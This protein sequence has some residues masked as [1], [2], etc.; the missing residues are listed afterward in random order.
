VR[1]VCEL[2][3]L[4][5]FWR[6]LVFSLCLFGLSKQWGDM[7]QLLPPFLERYFGEAVPYYAIASINMWVCMI[8]PSL[9]AALTSHL[10]PFVVM[11]P[12]IWIM[13]G[14]PLWLALQPSVETSIAWVALLS[15]G[16]AMW[17][18][19]Q[20]AWIAN[21]APEGRE[22]VSVFLVPCFLAHFL[23]HSF[24]TLPI[25]VFLALLSLKSLFTAIP[26]T[27]FNGWLNAQYNPNCLSCRDSSGHFC[28][29]A[30][31]LSPGKPH[32]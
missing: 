28:S 5:D 4:R 10:E 19:R 12:G 6:A 20:S 30:T 1:S 11:M 7:D 15:I 25:G 31:A 13:A 9:I 27:A 22:G 17:V 8:L 2:A 24:N 26:S 21:L 18:P 29:D 23:D 14:A 16:E 32:L 3:G